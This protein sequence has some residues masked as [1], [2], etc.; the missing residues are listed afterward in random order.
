MK[1]TITKHHESYLANLLATRWLMFSEA[2]IAEGENPAKLSEVIDGNVNGLYE[3]GS[4]LS[5]TKF[6]NA[7]NERIKKLALCFAVEALNS[8]AHPSVLA[9]FKARSAK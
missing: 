7:R 6:N 2:A 3:P 5:E 4:M 8:G 1:T 9:H